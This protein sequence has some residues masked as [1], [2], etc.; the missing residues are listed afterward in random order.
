MFYRKHS[1]IDSMTDSMILP[2]FSLIFYSSAVNFRPYKCERW[3][4]CPK[5]ISGK[6]NTV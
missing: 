2:R 4:N 1:M 6:H 3:K 5:I